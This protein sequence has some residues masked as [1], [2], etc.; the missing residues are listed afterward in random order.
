MD[1]RQSQW[2][3][4]R[5]SNCFIYLTGTVTPRLVLMLMAMAPSSQSSEE[6]AAL[7][8]PFCHI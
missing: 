5:N 3:M 2:E 6:V 4:P 1:V 7:V 8:T